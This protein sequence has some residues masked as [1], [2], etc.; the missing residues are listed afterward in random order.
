[1]SELRDVTSPSPGSEEAPQS[2]DD[3]DNDDDDN[4][5]VRQNERATAE[6]EE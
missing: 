1:M 5:I 4:H 3:D 6:K 2:Q